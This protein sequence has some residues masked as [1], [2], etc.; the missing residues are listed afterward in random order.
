MS[1][2]GSNGSS[3][4][5]GGLVIGLTGDTGGQVTAVAGNINVLGKK[6]NSAQV[7]MTEK[8][9]SDF[10]IENRNWESAYVVDAS[11]TAGVRGTYTT[12]QAAITAAV[13][14][15]VAA[16]N[17]VALI[18]IRDGQY[19]ENLTIPN[20]ARIQLKGQA[21]ILNVSTLGVNAVVTQILGSITLGNSSSYLYIE[22]ISTTTAG[23]NTIT[24]ANGS[25]VLA[26][27]CLLNTVTG[28]G[29]LYAYNCFFGGMSGVSSSELFNCQLDGTW[30]L[31]GTHRFNNCFNNPIGLLSIA[32]NT[33]ATGIIQNCIG[34]NISGDTNQQVV[35][36]NTSVRSNIN[37]PNA[38]LK[39]SGVSVS[40]GGTIPTQLITTSP[41]TL[42]PSSQGNVLFRRAVTTDGNVTS[43][44]QYLGCNKAGALAIS[45]VATDI[46]KGQ[47]FTFKDESGAAGA[48]NITITP[49][50]G[51]IDGGATYVMST[52]YQA[53]N[54]TFDGTNFFIF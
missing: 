32:F 53:I 39:T 27:N 42:L 11:S 37:L 2:G 10:Y 36:Q 16:G 3:G 45:L 47:V 5:G 25:L 29:N 19:T 23:T 41:T 48:N 20:N 8:I 24:M 22:N 35:I 38:T 1:Q 54:V 43:N 46:V 31:T 40:N 9:G 26:S 49:T 28:G 50:S 15:G 30:T 18:Y 14:D 52:N 21:P 12:I 44:D 34:F 33:T 4:G 13:A 6:S 7:M 17:D 51:T